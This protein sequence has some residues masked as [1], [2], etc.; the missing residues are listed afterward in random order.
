MLDGPGSRGQQRNDSKFSF[1]DM[2][3]ADYG[4]NE[5]LV[6]F[7][8]PEQMKRFENIKSTITKTF[9][10]PPLQVF[11]ESMVLEV[12]EDGLEQLGVLYKNT[13]HRVQAVLT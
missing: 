10:S 7:Y 11:I 2:K 3:S 1:I 8:H 5:T 4:V 12:N 13:H 9:D 6:A